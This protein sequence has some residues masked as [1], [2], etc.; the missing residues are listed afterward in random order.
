LG[1]AHSGRYLWTD[2]FAVLNFLTLYK[3]TRDKKYV[4][5]ALQLIEAVHSV[6]GF[7]RDGKSRL[8]PATDQEPL[9]GGLRI[10]KKD[11]GGEDGD[12]QYFHYLTV[13]IFALVQTSEATGSDWYRRQAFSLAKAIHPKFMRNR[14]SERPKMFWK[15]SMDLKQPLVLS[16][17]R[18]YKLEHI[19][20]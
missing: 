1:D 20:L 19:L 17:V 2:G 10:G 9:L 13:W 12:G 15:M 3:V 16:E 4:T 18:F 7:T 6:L 5:L 11:E 14:S 8:S